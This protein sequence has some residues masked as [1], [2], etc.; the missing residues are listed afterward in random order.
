[1]PAR[2]NT[3]DANQGV[4]IVVASDDRSGRETLR[5]LISSWGFHARAI[6]SD[7]VLEQAQSFA[8]HVLLVDLKAQ[9]K[10]IVGV[11]HGI[12]STRNRSRD[13]S[14]G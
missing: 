7:Q 2:S 8:A 11:L 14:D 4:R 5:D 3:P 12:A 13:Y 6:A 9:E 1:M 10:D